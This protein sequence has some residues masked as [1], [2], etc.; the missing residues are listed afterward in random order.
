MAVAL[1]LI[2]PISLSLSLPLE[3]IR[4][5]A[6]GFYFHFLSSFAISPKVLILKNNTTEKQ[7]GSKVM[8]LIEDLQYLYE[9]KDMDEE[10]LAS[11]SSPG[12][13]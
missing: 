4:K 13:F 2:F 12:T 7:A 3:G 8:N 6:G 5:I 10:A 11:E 1:E 9:M